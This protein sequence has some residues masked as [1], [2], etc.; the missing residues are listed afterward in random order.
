MTTDPA[1]LARSI[2]ALT[3]DTGGTILD[4]HTGV[5]R[6]MEAVGAETGVHA[7]WPALAK[8]WRR[9]STGM[10]N[11]G[12]PEAGGQASIDM[13][14]VLRLTLD[15]V[16]A[17]ARLPLAATMRERL[18]RGW[19]DLDPWPDVP[20]GLPRLRESFVVV[21]FTIL[22]TELVIQA[23]RRARLS[24]DCV[25]SC[26]MIGISKTHPVAYA[27]AARWLGLQP[28]QILMVTTHNN[29]LKASHANGFRTAFVHRREQWADIP[30]PDP[31]IPIRSRTSSAKT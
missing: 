23:S 21:P 27:T 25:I 29:D 31:G 7:D 9:L 15:T 2:R 3:F 17:E 6:A 10:V 13:D 8:Q 14:G 20:G 24:W 11:D 1:K 26:E 19:R 5:V 16:L 30:S 4:W 28:E 18:V 12:L 22:N